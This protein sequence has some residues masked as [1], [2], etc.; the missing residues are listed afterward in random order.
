MVWGVELANFG[1]RRCRNGEETSEERRWGGETRGWK[2]VEGEREGGCGG[3]KRK[4]DRRGNKGIR[5]ELWRGK[6]S[7][8]GS[9][10]CGLGSV[11]YIS[12]YYIQFGSGK[13]V[14]L[15]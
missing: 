3:G 1:G 4:E 9:A 11:K 7:E 14:G 8:I 15:L 13:G 5:K 12:I 10:S 2:G 6:F